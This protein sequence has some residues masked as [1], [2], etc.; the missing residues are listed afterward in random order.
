VLTAVG[1]GDVGANLLFAAA[2][3]R[4]LLSLVAVAGSLYPV[5]TLVLARFVHHERLARIQYAGVV[6]AIG[7]VA[8]IAAGGA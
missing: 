3:T 7:G 6:G 4:G 5:A 8:L 2:S 1:L